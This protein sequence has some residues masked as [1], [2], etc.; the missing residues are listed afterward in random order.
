MQFSEFMDDI[1][2]NLSESGSL[3]HWGTSRSHRFVS[4]VRTQRLE[5]TRVRRDLEGQ[6]APSTG[7]QEP[8]QAGQYL[9]S[10]IR[11]ILGSGQ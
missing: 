2:T 4:E 8:F 7:L 9:F 11:P 3:S 5:K 10:L 6:L 1:I